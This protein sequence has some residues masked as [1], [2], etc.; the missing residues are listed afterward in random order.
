ML[1]DA[2]LSG[3]DCAYETASDEFQAKRADGNGSARTS[4]S[5]REITRAHA[6][7]LRGTFF[8]LVTYWIS[9]QS[10][11]ACIAVI[12]SNTPDQETP[13]MVANSEV[14]RYIDA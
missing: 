6:D 13:W 8:K 7:A 9:A 10:L 5:N 4:L 14:Q 1:F 3:I 12:G 11:Y 2:N